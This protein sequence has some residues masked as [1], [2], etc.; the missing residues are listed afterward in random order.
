MDLICRDSI[1]SCL[2]GHVHRVHHHGIQTYRLLELMG[3]V[4][5]IPCYFLPHKGCPVLIST[6]VINEVQLTFV[7]QIPMGLNSPWPT[8]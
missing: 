7:D 4:E 1:H 3:E 6:V 2:S 5:A 8:L